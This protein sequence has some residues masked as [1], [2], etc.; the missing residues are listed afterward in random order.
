MNTDPVTLPFLT[1]QGL[2]TLL[3]GAGVF[4]LVAL[5]WL[6]L[7]GDERKKPVRV[8][9]WLFAASWWLLP[10]W[11]W[12]LGATLWGLWQVFNGTPSPLAGGS[13]GLG[14][15]IAAFLGAPF[16]IYGTWLKHKTNRLHQEGHM[17]DRINKAVEQ[18]GA[19]K[20]VERIGRPVKVWTGKR[21]QFS[22]FKPR[23]G[24]P[25]LKARQLIN[26][27]KDSI[28]YHEET[29]DVAEGIDYEVHEWPQEVTLIEWQGEGIKKN[30]SDYVAEYGAWEVFKETV[31]NTEVRIGA[32]LS[33][34]RIAQDSTLHDKGRDHVRV[35]EILCA[36]IRENSPA[37]RAVGK[38]PQ[39][40][41]IA[42]LNE[43]LEKKHSFLES[44]LR[45]TAE[46]SSEGAERESIEP[47][48]SQKIIRNVRPDIQM[49]L[50]VI[51]RRSFDQ[52]QIERAKQRNTATFQADI[53]RS[54]R[55]FATGFEKAVLREQLATIRQ[56]RKEIYCLDLREVNF[57]GYSLRGLDF[58]YADMSKSSFEMA[59]LSDAN[60]FAADISFSRFNN[61]DISH[62]KLAFADIAY[63]NFLICTGFSASFIGNTLQGC[64]FMGGVFSSSEFLGVS[65]SGARFASVNLHG[66]SIISHDG[67]NLD[68]IFCRF[69]N[70]F[71]RGVS[72]DQLSSF[73]IRDDDQIIIGGR[74]L[75]GTAFQDTFFDNGTV[76]DA[77]FSLAFGDGSVHLPNRFPRPSHWPDWKLPDDGDHA[78]NTEWSEWQA[79]PNTYLPPPE[80]K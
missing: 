27:S 15:L 47:E 72:F 58:S 76:I 16:V 57:Q 9:S 31:P 63:C 60:L 67:G 44:Y 10:V 66:S 64:V 42:K 7:F 49:A 69:G 22:W 68:I 4:L 11:F 39:N 65:T 48:W 75:E 13:L 3:V 29:D 78:F 41:F 38:D 80:H 50:N 51:G 77:D 74:N 52:T 71:L 70:A 33:L 43:F 40:D 79:N 26:S 21:T 19:D 1:W 14:A 36:Y 25:A 55:G 24:E 2:H 45:A 62:T 6:M 17:T 23:G 12:L 61:T 28:S 56:S 5:V 30:P 46:V 18:L 59:N 73:F 53:L 37:S 32:I 8:E 35:M 54:A 20:I 34:E